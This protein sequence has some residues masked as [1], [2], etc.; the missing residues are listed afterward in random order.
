[1]KNLFWG[2]LLAFCIAVVSLWLGD[3]LQFGSVITALGIGVVL[4]NL[5]I[6]RPNFDPGIRFS[7]KSILETSIVLLGFGL[8]FNYLK[9]VSL[10]LFF[11]IGL[12]VI[13][14]IA[15]SIWIGK[16]IGL[17]KNTGVLLGV[18]SAICGTAA[19][20]AISPL[21]KSNENE[22]ALSIGVINLLGTLGLVFLPA[23][24]L[25]LEFGPQESGFLL[26]GVL[27]SVGH[28]TGAAFS[29]GDETGKLALIYK[30]GRILWIIPLILGMYF[31]QR[32][33]VNTGPVIKFPGFIVF[34]LLA[35]TLAQFKAIPGLWKES[36]VEIGDF[37]LIVAMAA[38][39]YKIKLKPLF[40]VAKSALITGVIIFVMQILLFWI[41]L[42]LRG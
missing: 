41:I 31:I 11:I 35:V 8:N 14:V 13:L 23:L 18:G 39:G 22:T 30:M 40:Y 34:F 24:M 21:L 7:E 25:V 17:N 10:D 36:L 38:I 12:S 32:R 20:A 19:I 9:S 37:L 4:G 16:R 26:G 2:I 5:Q 29:L 33:T 28:V 15:F 6:K 1:M 42:N 3:I 27:Q